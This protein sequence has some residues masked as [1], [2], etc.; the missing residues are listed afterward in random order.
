[1]IT[2]TPQG[3][4][5]LCKTPLENDYNHQLT[6]ANATAQ[7]TYFTNT[8]FKT[9]TDFYY[10][11]KDSQMTVPYN[12]DEIISCNYLF[13]KN[14]GF[15]TKY[16]YCFISNM[17]YVSEN[18]TRITFETDVFQTYQFDL[19][20]KRCFVER[21]HVND[22]TIGI[23]TTPEGL[24]T[25]EYI[26]NDIDSIG[27]ESSNNPETRVVIGVTK[28]PKEVYSS[29]STTSRQYN[30]ILNGLT[31]YV[32]ETPTDAANFIDAMDLSGLA[33]NVVN[34][35]LAPNKL[36][37]TS[38]FYTYTISILDFGSVTLDIQFSCN[39]IPSESSARVLK[40]STT[41]SI[42]STLNGYTPKN[43]KMFTK[44]FNYLHITNNNG[45]DINLAYEDFVNN[46]P[47]YRIIGAITPGCSIRFIPE[48]YKKYNTSS[49]K[50]LLMEY[51]LVAG[52]YP[53]CSWRSDTYTNWLT[54]NSVNYT[55]DKVGTAASLGIAMAVNPGIAAIGGIGLITEALQETQKRETSPIQAKGNV[56]VGDVTYSSGMNKFTYSKMSCRYEYAKRIDDYLSMYGYKVNEVKIPNFTGRTNWNYVKTINC[57]FE[58]DIPQ[59][60][61]NKI[62]EIF[63]KGITLWHN[64]STMLDYSQSNT[65]VS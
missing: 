61:L 9:C 54:Q 33:D 59:Q 4:V 16:Y 25:G 57:D 22:D 31:Y 63:N 28:V 17:E 26:V 23:N 55:I 64:P 52:K 39:K 36:C 34:V 21:E 53:V 32:F 49:N 60:Y 27:Y 50:N 14:T 15:T 41:I 7:Q 45:N 12:I 42:N 43:N 48:N 44:E 37:N 62:K 56:N 11:K 58:G 65:I 5:Y 24:D 51:G 13:Y 6:F 2:V 8:I 18:S 1:M 46:T 30:G 20:K 40:D 10:V 29:M 47:T 19:V 3:S 35:F 38:T